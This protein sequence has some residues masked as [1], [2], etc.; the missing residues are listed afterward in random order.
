MG[1]REREKESLGLCWVKWGRGLGEG[2]AAIN[3]LVFHRMDQSS[4]GKM[5]EK[6]KKKKN[7]LKKKKNYIVK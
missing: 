6:G 2:I 4:K 5:I 3:M 7:L 1:R